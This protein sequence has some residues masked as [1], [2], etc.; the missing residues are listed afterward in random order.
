MVHSTE[1]FDFQSGF[2][3]I[4]QSLGDSRK[5]L[6]IFPGLGPASLEPEQPD[7]KHIGLPQNRVPPNPLQIII[8]LVKHIL[9]G[10]CA[11]HA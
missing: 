3:T 9:W 7:T 1:T 10:G 8:V 2:L 4:H 11:N 6:W 5:I